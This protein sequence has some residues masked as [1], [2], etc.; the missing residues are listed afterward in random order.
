M[1]LMTLPLEL[2]MVYSLMLIKDQMMEIMIVQK[3]NLERVN[4]NMEIMEL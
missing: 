3:V 2:L 4:L 1:M